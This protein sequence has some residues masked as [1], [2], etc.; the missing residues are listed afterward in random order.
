ML[1]ISFFGIS[2][3]RS[4]RK[5]FLFL[6]YNNVTTQNWEILSYFEL[7]PKTEYIFEKPFTGIIS[8]M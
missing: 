7:L 4:K 8:Y 3:V 1:T 6:K 2:N 5:Y